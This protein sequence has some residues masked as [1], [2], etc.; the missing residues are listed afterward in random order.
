M[1][2]GEEFSKCCSSEVTTK[3]AIEAIL[4]IDER[5]QVLFPKELREK[6]KL[7]PGDK[8]VAV[9]CSKGERICCLTL[10][11]AEDLAKSVKNFLGSFLKELIK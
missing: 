5:G 10:V 7:K 6:F 4:V 2:K 9:S 1:I 3:C 8:L 11:K